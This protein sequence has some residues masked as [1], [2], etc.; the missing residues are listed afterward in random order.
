MANTSFAASPN[1]DPSKYGIGENVPAVV[2]PSV[3]GEHEDVV[4]L[5]ADAGHGEA[6]EGRE[7]DAPERVDRSGVDVLSCRRELHVGAVEV[8]RERPG[9]A[10]SDRG[11]GELEQILVLAGHACDGNRIRRREEE[12][13]VREELGRVDVLPGERQTYVG[14]VEVE[15]ERAPPCPSRATSR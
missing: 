8:E 4:V 1:A 14:A 6:V 5:A 12:V 2:V 10:R 11:R 9:R 3:E 13:P 15:G 7:V